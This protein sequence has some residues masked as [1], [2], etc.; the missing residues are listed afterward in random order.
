MGKGTLT[1]LVLFWCIVFASGIYTGQCIAQGNQG[2]EDVGISGE[3]LVLNEKPTTMVI[4]LSKIELRTADKEVIGVQVDRVIRDHVWYNSSFDTSV[5]VDRV[6]EDSSQVVPY[7]E[8]ARTAEMMVWAN[9]SVVPLTPS[10]ALKKEDGYYYGSDGQGN[11]A[12]Q[13]CPDKAEYPTCEFVIENGSEY[14]VMYDTHGFNAVAEQAYL[15]RDE[16]NLSIA[17]MDMPDKAKAALY[18]AQNGIPCYAPCDRFANTLMNYKEELGIETEILGSAPIRQTDCGAVI[19]DQPVVISLNESIIAQYTD[20]PYPDQYCDTPSRYFR[21]LQKVYNVNLSVTEVYANVGETSNLVKEAKEQNAGVIGARIFTEADYLPLKEW[22]KEDKNHRAILFHSA[23]YNFGIKLFREFPK[24][25]SFGDINPKFVS[26][27]LSHSD[28]EEKR[29]NN[30]K[31]NISALVSFT[32]DDDNT[33]HLE[34]I[35][36]LLEEYNMKATRYYIT[37]VSWANFTECKVLQDHYGWEI[38]SHTR[39]HPVLTNITL[40]EARDEICG[41]RDDFIANGITVKSFAPPY[42]VIDTDTM[43]I[44]KECYESCRDGWGVNYHPYENYHIKVVSLYNKDGLTISA[45]SDKIDE[46][47]KNKGWIVFIP[48]KVDSTGNL[49]STDTQ[50]FKDV[51]D[52]ISERPEVK[53]VTVS[54]ALAWEW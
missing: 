43:N 53:V 23:A 18:L 16:I 34:Y 45:L 12:F 25:T 26:D 35:A 20:S 31:E 29:T 44:T 7:M 48:H 42:T 52:L 6:P 11:F 38:G 32:F 8:G 27:N 10:I 54:E 28:T 36:P 47:I 39:T 24:Q 4:G 41:S 9:V 2:Q 51:L 17:C 33:N 37:G 5:P 50:F 30:E 40:E 21:E 15:K 19:G 3:H 13:I 1:V 22:L 49:Y 14:V 46:A